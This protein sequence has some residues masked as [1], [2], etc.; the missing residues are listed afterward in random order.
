[1]LGCSYSLSPSQQA[2]LISNPI[3][4]KH[5]AA[6]SVNLLHHYLFSAILLRGAFRVRIYYSS[7]GGFL[8]KFSSNLLYK[9]LVAYRFHHSKSGLSTK[10]FQAII[11]INTSFSP[12]FFQQP[13]FA[14]SFIQTC[15][16]FSLFAIRPSNYEAMIL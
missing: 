14:Y 8:L 7:S 16:L 6:F 4:F 11:F 12:Y 3:S 1:M 5:K 15:G 10:P 2:V 13:D 9:Y